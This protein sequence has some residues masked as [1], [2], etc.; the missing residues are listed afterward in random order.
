MRR[1]EIVSAV[2]AACLLAA[3]QPAW[4]ARPD[5]VRILVPTFGGSTGLGGNVA[6]ILALRI[7]TTFRPRP[8]GANPQNLYF[9]RGEFAWSRKVVEDSPE[10]ALQA[11]TET[12]SDLALWGGAAE[13]G[14]GVVVTANLVVSQNPSAAAPLRKWTVTVRDQKLELGLPSTSWQ[15]SPLVIGNDLVAKYSRPNQLR[16]CKEKAVDCDGKPLGNPFREIRV[17]GDF[18]QV[19]QPSGDVGWVALPKLAEAQGEVVDFNAA[20]IS[21]LRG[22]FE[23]AESYFDSVHK[24]PA[25]VVIRQDAGLLAGLARFRRG[26]GID[27]LR[28]AHAEN[29]YSR[30][31]VQ[32]VVMADIASAAALGAGG[33]RDGH[34]KEARELTSSYRHLFAAEDPWLRSVERYLQLLQ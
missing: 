5:T 3:A 8:P 2:L 14:S 10:E 34:L 28:A 11:A 27:A 19:R 30:Y 21:Y 29:P 23:Q 25:E 26:L 22:D 17:E 15:F 18:V 7:W 1:Q 6:T 9:G 20:L 24:S 16:V 31:A 33:V 32:A 12:E 13:Y 4:S